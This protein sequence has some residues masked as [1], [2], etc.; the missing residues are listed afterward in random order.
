[1]SSNFFAESSRV[2]CRGSGTSSHV[3]ICTS[4]KLKVNMVVIWSPQVSFSQQ[5]IVHFVCHNDGN[6]NLLIVLVIV[7]GMLNPS[8]KNVKKKGIRF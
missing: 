6:S 7:D 8:D 3:I 1:M 5:I 2:T 4:L